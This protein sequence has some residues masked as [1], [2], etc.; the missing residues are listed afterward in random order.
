MLPK[1]ELGGPEVTQKSLRRKT[2]DMDT[3]ELEVANG[4]EIK[5]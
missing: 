1:N 5:A 4:R 2:S 3:H